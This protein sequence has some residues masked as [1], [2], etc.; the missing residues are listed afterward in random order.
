MNRWIRF[1]I[2]SPQRFLATLLAV[3]V[4]VCMI[5]PALFEQALS[6]AVSAILHSLGPLLGP[7]LA[8]VIVFAGLRMIV[9]GGKK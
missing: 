9:F 1:F 2:G 8:V 7:V 4:I 6:N 3:G 5:N